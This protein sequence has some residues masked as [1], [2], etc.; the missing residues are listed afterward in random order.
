MDYW[1]E[2]LGKDHVFLG[3]QTLYTSR[4]AEQ[5]DANSI[6]D[7]INGAMNRHIQ[8]YRETLYLKRYFRGWHPILE[9]AKKVRPDINNRIPINNAF[10]IVRNGV[11]YFL[12]EPIQYNE[13]STPNSAGVKRLNDFLDSEDKSSEDMSVGNDGSICGRGFRL[14]A[15]DKP[16]FED[17]APFELPTLDSECTEVIYSTKAGHPPVLAFTHSPILSDSGSVSGTEWTA[18]D[19]ENQY[20]YVVPGGFGAHLQRKHLAGEPVSHFLRDIPI[21]EYPNNEW[22]IGDFEIVLA[23]LDAI[24]K[25]Q[26]DRVNSVEQIVS[27]ILVFVGCHLRTKEEKNN[28]EPS[29]YEQLQETFTLEIPADTNGQHADVKYVNSGVDQNEAETLAQTLMAY[30]YSITGIPDRKDRAGGGGDTGDAV[31]LRDGYQSLEIVAR[32]KERNFRKAERRLL[33]MICEIIRRFNGI[34]L[35]PMDIDV[36]FI[37]NRTTDLLNKSQAFANLMGTKQI[38]PTDG[39]SLIGVTNDP[40][41]MAKRGQYY[42]SGPGAQQNDT[43]TE[44]NDDDTGTESNQEPAVG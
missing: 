43:A 1:D 18:Y 36:K 17:E 29:D 6:P 40:Q 38:A 22:R 34:N 14:I 20:R 2:V 32:V 23:I 15:A 30:V 9:R 31:Y 8:N 33:R 16:E 41:G 3:R 10:A 13:K 42:W 12:G 44:G 24:D 4:T 7:I 11:G 37:R 5:I 28:G 25:L 19:S 26:S 39:I 21:V 27:S 35:R